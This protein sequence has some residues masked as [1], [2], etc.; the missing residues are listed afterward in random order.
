MKVLVTGGQGYL[1]SHLVEQLLIDGHTVHCLSRSPMG[2]LP[3]SLMQHPGFRGFCGSFA[4]PAGLDRA[5]EGCQLCVHLGWS[6]LPQPSNSDPRGDLSTNLLGTLELLEACGRAGL[7]RLVF[8]SSGGT[9]YGVP[10]QVPIRE[11]HPTEPTCA[12]GISKLAAEKYVSLYARL[13]QLRAV[14]L[15]VANPYGGRQRLDAPQG[16]VAVFLGR[17]LRGE[18]IEIWGDGTVVRDFVALEDVMGAL[19]QAIALTDGLPGGEH[20]LLNIGSGE[21]LSL[22]N[23]VD[24]LDQSLGRPLERRY[25]PGRSFDVP[26]SVLSIDRARA[27]L[28]WCPQLGL[29]EGIRAFYG[30]FRQRG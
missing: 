22:N 19:R 11:D 25:L 24:L 10:Q 6:S 20:R 29:Q 14:T 9:V 15:R 26:V 5:L 18:P 4:D 28:D 8:V 1:G 2:L 13:R 3:A 30:R 21:G 17:A 7:Q 27:E 16:A 23:L 12:Y